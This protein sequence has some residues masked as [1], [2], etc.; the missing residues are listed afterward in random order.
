[1]VNE[2]QILNAIAHLLMEEHIVAEPAAAATSAAWLADS[3]SE[4]SGSIV[5]LVTGSNI[6]KSVLRQAVGA[7]G[8]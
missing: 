8:N 4:N 2:A 1:L 3:G 7:A 6:A 5:L